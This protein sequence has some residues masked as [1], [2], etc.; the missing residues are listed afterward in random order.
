M[1]GLEAAA[2]ILRAM[3]EADKGLYT[4]DGFS[5]ERTGPDKYTLTIGAKRVGSNMSQSNALGRLMA[6]F[7]PMIDWGK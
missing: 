7:Y 1:N 5:L 4:G 2:K 3:D 6:Y